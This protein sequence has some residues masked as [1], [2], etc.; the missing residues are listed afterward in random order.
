M[1][2]NI[3]SVIQVMI[4]NVTSI[5]SGVLVGFL[6]PKILSVESFGL[7]KT[8][9]LY[10]TYLGLFS[11][12]IIDG[13]V[14]TYGEKNYDEL[15]R[16]EFCSYFKW[17]V[18]IHL[19]FG[20]VLCISTQF[21]SNNEVKYIICA[22]AIYMISNN[23]TGYFQQISQIT[24][25]FKE[26]S[27]RKILQSLCNTLIILTLFIAFKNGFN[28]TYHIYLNFWIAA[29][30]LLMLWYVYTYRD[31]VFSKAVPLKE[32]KQQ[33]VKLMLI[34]FPLLFANLCS[35][36]I[37]TIDRQF[38]NVLFSTTTYAIYAFAYNI[39]SLVTIATSAI[40]T[41]LYP[42]LKRTNGKSLKENYKYFIR[43]ILIF[44]FGAMIIYFPL[45]IFIKFFLPKYIDSLAIF[46]IIFPGLAI[47]S[48][49]TVVMHNYYKVFGDN[50]IFFKKSVVVLLVSGITNYIA[51]RIF[52]TDISISIASIITMVFWYIY[53]EDYFVK[54]YNYKRE[55]NLIYMLLMMC[56]FYLITGILTEIFGFIIYLVLFVSISYLFFNKNFSKFI[57]LIRK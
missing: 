17:Y 56:V 32:T 50:L 41:V 19:L 13:I 1:S 16:A 6:L 10:S 24:M 20:I 7:Y 45:S 28:I 25:K 22:L 43:I 40:A 36:F 55:K 14:L 53:V 52:R 49:I 26:L 54:K 23:I 3:R 35:S 29:N 48:A 5:V 42:V 51:Y 18:L 12:G 31:I 38:V 46:R 8:F 15:N 47:S 11:L 27:I 44:I 30:V 57:S 37:L 34:G 9:T 39:L 21:F 4:S 33:I 2:R